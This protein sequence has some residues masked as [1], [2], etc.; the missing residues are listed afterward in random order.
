MPILPFP[1]IQEVEYKITFSNIT[2]SITG[3]TDTKNMD[4]DIS[5]EIV[6]IMILT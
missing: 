6:Y 3:Q 5:L 4:S 1:I 2:N